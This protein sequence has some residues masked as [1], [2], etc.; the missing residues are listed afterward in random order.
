M[1]FKGAS[2]KNQARLRRPVGELIGNGQELSTEEI[3][4]NLISKLMRLREERLKIPKGTHDR[5]RIGQEIG[6]LETELGA[7]KRKGAG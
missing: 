2:N 1:A 4:Q 5:R 7:L 6:E 3:R